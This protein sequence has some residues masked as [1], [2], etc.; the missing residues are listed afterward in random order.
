MGRRARNAPPLHLWLSRVAYVKL[1]FVVVICFFWLHKPSSFFPLVPFQSLCRVNVCG[2]REAAVD[3]C[4]LL[5]SSRHVGRA[6]TFPSSTAFSGR[7]S[8]HAPSRL[9]GVVSGRAFS[10]FPLFRTTFDVN[11]VPLVARTGN[12][13]SPLARPSLAEG[14]RRGMET[15]PRT[16]AAAVPS[17]RPM[18]L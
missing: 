2:S 10:S 11:F 3:T 13:K 18:F 1:A 4:P 6:P 16:R 5:F 15:I 9:H 14:G 7:T 8:T 12:V 17:V